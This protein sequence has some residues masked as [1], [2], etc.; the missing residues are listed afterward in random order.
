V[1]LE[2]QTP[3]TGADVEQRHIFTMQLDSVPSATPG[4]LTG[5]SISIKDNIDV[6][7]VTTTAGSR[8]FAMRLPATEDAGVVK[9]LRA[10]GARVF[11]K[12][13][14][15]EFAY[16]TLGI[17]PHFGTPAN[18]F[19][20]DGE[21]RIPG[22]SSSGAAVAVA[23]GL[24]DA[25]IGTDT[26]GSARIPAA[27][28]GVAGFKP[29]QRRIPLEGV[30]PLS[31]SYDCI[32]ILA[33]TVPDIA[34]VFSAL[35]RESSDGVAAKQPAG[36][37]RLLVSTDESAGDREAVADDVERAFSNAIRVL[38]ADRRF[39]I[40][41][42]PAGVL[43]LALEMSADGGVVAPEAYAFHK[44]LLEAFRA[45]Y[46]PFTLHRLGFGEKCTA[47]RYANLLAR[48]QELI[49]ECRQQWADVDAVVYPTCPIVAPTLKSMGDPEVK[50]ATNLRLMRNTVA[51]NVLDIASISIPCG[52][53]FGS[54]AG[55]VG[56]SL[57]S[58]NTE[59]HLLEIAM[60][61]ENALNSAALRK[62]A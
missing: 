1:N 31:S 42:R 60:T 4:V 40:I 26:A 47:E 61:V 18:P 50:A 37:Y 62:E 2:V 6:E 23:L 7:G 10:A 39:A 19:P 59:E 32:G 49:A 9:R 14:M 36:P 55:P 21:P 53:L 52:H 15:S 16:S 44:P 57:D 34:R 27:L 28:C 35:A 41:Q 29:R 38:S 24:G 12:T 25:A 11:A 43:R 20:F 46:D 54:S 51:A 8:A 45:L 56:L 48:R 30:V 3:V 17:N 58:H 22:G 5:H 13:N 33:K